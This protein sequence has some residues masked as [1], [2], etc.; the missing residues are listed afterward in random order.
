MR[1]RILAIQLGSWKFVKRIFY[2][3]MVLA[4]FVSYAYTTMTGGNLKIPIVSNLGGGQKSL[5]ANLVL[6]GAS[7]GQGVI[8]EQ[9]EGGN[10]KLLGGAVAAEATFAT[11][12]TDLSAA[13]CYPNPFKPSMGHTKIRFT[14]LTRDIEIKIYTISGE[15]IKTLKKSDANDYIEWD[16]KNS[17]GEDLASGVYL[18]LI[19]SAGQTKKGKLMIIR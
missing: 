5:G 11:A 13:H 3:G 17:N 10:Y 1:K 8:G 9:M 16:A 4:A 12:K 18:Y 15:L 19:K 6:N 7:I 14:K 2:A